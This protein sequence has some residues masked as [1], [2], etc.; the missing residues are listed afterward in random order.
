MTKTLEMIFD[1]LESISVYAY[2]SIAAYLLA[3]MFALMA[4]A[5]GL[6]R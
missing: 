5:L 4:Q 6:L 3:H 1:K 2:V